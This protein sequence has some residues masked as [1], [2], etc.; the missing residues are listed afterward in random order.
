[1]TV[2]SETVAAFG[3]K[4]PFLISG[5]HFLTRHILLLSYDQIYNLIAES[6]AMKKLLA[7]CFLTLMSLTVHAHDVTVVT[8]NFPPYNYEKEGRAAGMSSEV[9]KALLERVGAN[10]DIAFYPWARSY[11]LARLN[12]NHLIYSIARIP[13]RENLFEWIGEIAPYQTS[14]Y[15]LK[16]RTDID[17]NSLDDARKYSIGSSIADV[18]TTFLREEGFTTL[19]VVS[20]D[21]QNIQRLLHGRVDLIAYDEASFNYQIR[22]QGLDPSQ[23][24]RVFRISELSEQLYVAFSTNTDPELVRTFRQ[25]LKELREEGVLARIHA[26]YFG[27]G[28]AA[29]LDTP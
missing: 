12:K 1:M 11:R 17:L 4:N 10:Y 3:T 21:T 29:L 5:L 2:V 23:F 13:E 28:I 7:A 18:I 25:S 27:N 26:R 6:K 24:E 22:E 9:V 8:E 19:E 20:R 16:S 15:K 14:L